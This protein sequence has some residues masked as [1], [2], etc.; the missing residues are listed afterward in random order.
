MPSAFEKRL[1]RVVAALGGAGEE[2]RIDRTPWPNPRNRARLHPVE[3][4]P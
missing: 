4:G 2:N 1:N 3:V